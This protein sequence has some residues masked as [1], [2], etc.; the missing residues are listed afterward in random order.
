VVASAATSCGLGEHTGTTTTTRVLGES[1]G[2][3]LAVGR[4]APAGTGE[5]DSVSCADARRCWAVGVVGPNPALPGGIA[6]IVATTDGGASWKSQRVAGG[7]TPQLSAISCPTTTQCMAVGSNGSSLPGSGVVVT[8]TKAS[9]AWSPAAAP[10][11]ALA[12]TS[13]ACTGTASCTAIASDG[14]ATW[15]AQSSDFGQTWQRAGNL[16][17]PFMPGN[18]LSCA[19][20]GTCLVAGYVPSTNGHGTGAVAVSANAGQTWALG[21]VPPGTGVL[22]SATCLSATVCVAAGTTSTT[23]SDVVP[24]NGELL[25][26]TDGG[27]TWTA[28]T[29]TVPVDAVY[30]IDCPSAR[31]CAMVGT[32]WS[33]SPA[34]AT[35]AAAQSRDAGVTFRAASAAYV[36]LTLTGLSCPTTSLCIAVGGNTLVRLTLLPPTAP[37]S[38]SSPG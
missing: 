18:D 6:V 14:T 15:A 37:G 2:T 20:G 7:S 4:P 33:G 30:G 36:P 34:V 28:S 22:Q 23:V 10:A 27:H 26:S 21:T 11:N 12:V 31:Q 16:P 29:R 5:L 24:A 8:R 35:G 38:G 32:R 17:A 3:P 25:R 13:V 1:G 9:P 19:G